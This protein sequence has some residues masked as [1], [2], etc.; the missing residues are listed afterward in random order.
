MASHLLYDPEVVVRNAVSLTSMR[1]SDAVVVNDRT[2]VSLQGRLNH[3]QRNDRRTV[4]EVEVSILKGDAPCITPTELAS[5]VCQEV[6]IIMRREKSSS[7][8]FCL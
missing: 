2:E 8:N 7:C 5:V 3:Q 6:V 4:Y 1:N